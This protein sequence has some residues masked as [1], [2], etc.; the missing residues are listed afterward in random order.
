MG[1]IYQS[2]YSPVPTSST[3][4]RSPSPALRIDEVLTDSSSPCV[5]SPR[6]AWKRRTPSALYLPQ[7]TAT[8]DSL[9]SR[10]HL[11]ARPRTNNSFIGDNRQSTPSSLPE[12]QGSRD[13]TVQLSE[14]KEEGSG[15]RQEPRES[16]YVTDVLQ[17]KEKINAALLMLAQQ[18]DAVANLGKVLLPLLFSY[19]SW[20]VSVIEMKGSIEQVRAVSEH[21]RQILQ[22][23]I[24]CCAHSY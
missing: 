4:P 6:T 17:S 1:S 9:P 12:R 20:T 13:S 2:S 22:R 5:I 10:A 19:D 18:L 15:C 8:D 7:P 24:H 3:S 23:Y 11:Q 21:I 14:P 16:E